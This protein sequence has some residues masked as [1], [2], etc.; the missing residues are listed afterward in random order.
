MPAGGQDARRLPHDGCLAAPRAAENEHRRLPLPYE[1]VLH[2][3]G[4]AVDR[5]PHSQ[6]QPVDVSRLGAHGGNAVEAPV[7]AGSVVMP[8]LVFESRDHRVQ[9]TC[10][11]D[12]LWIGVQEDKFAGAEEGPRAGAQVQ[13]DVPQL[14]EGGN[15]LEQV[16]RLREPAETLR[17]QIQ[18]LLHVVLDLGGGRAVSAE[19]LRWPRVFQEL[20]RVQPSHLVEPHSAASRLLRQPLAPL[21]GGRHQ[22]VQVLV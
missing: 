5:P 19:L 4:V 21:L 15:P 10:L 6:R 20:P 14:V 11:H 7:D 22:R 1:H 16:P 13:H 12:R 9:V 2:Y 8:K 3:L 18:E 17:H